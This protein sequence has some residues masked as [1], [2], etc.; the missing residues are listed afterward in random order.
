MSLTLQEDLR[1]WICGHTVARVSRY[2]KGTSPSAVGRVTLRPEWFDPANPVTARKL[3]AVEQLVAL[4]KDVG[5]TLSALATAFPLAHRAVTSVIIGPRTA[6]QLEDSLAS[7]DLR[8]DDDALDRIDEIVPPGS[9]IYSPQSASLELPW[10]T[11]ATL[12][13]STRPRQ[14]AG[15]AGQ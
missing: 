13:R 7:M 8:L 4:A 12:R 3:D 9:D 2:R 14:P 1:K 11:D 10:L 6:E 15:G 5:C